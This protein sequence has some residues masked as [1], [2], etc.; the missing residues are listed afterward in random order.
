MENISPSKKFDAT[1]MV[2]SIAI[3][4]S[5]TDLARYPPFS[6]HSSPSTIQIAK[7]TSFA[8]Q[9]SYRRLRELESN[10]FS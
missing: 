5:R 9:T 3:S 1:R 7:I 2:S 4:A 8:R 6:I 10:Q